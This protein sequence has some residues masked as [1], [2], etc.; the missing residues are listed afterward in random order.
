MFSSLL[1]DVKQQVYVPDTKSDCGI[2]GVGFADQASVAVPISDLLT[3]PVDELKARYH[4]H[5]G[6][7][8]GG[9]I[10]ALPTSEIAKH[11]DVAV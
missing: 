8:G 7:D 5:G 4:N 11:F 3:C 9:M 6:G 2:F 10:A 1:N